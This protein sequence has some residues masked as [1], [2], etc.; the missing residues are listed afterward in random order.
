MSD[1]KVV[2]IIM[3]VYNGG[4]FLKDSVEDILAQTYRD[5]ELFCIYDDGTTDG[6]DKVLEELARKDSRLIVIH[7]EERGSNVCRN[8]GLREA[9]GKYV[10]FLDA[11]DRFEQDMLKLCVDKAEADN[12]DVVAFDGDLFDSKSGVHRGAP[13]LIRSSE[14]VST[15]DPFR[16][17][18]ATIW[19]KM[20]RRDL[21]IDNDIRFNK[22]LGGFPTYFVFMA[23][24]YASNIG[25]VR[26][27]L[28]HYR[29]NNENSLTASKENPTGGFEEF[30][31]VKKR[32]VRDGRFEEKK[33]IFER[34]AKE[35]MTDKLR[36]LRTKS[37]SETLYELL[38]TRGVD[39]LG[40]FTE[41]KDKDF[42][43]FLF[44]QKMSLI[45]SGVI[46]AS[47]F[48]LPKLHE[49]DASKIALY[50]G[51]EVGKDYA[52]QIMRSGNLKLVC[53]A[54]RNFERIGYPLQS[55]E[56]LKD[57]DYDILLIAVSDKKTADIITRDL[58]SMGI[59]E[60]KIFWKQ[61]EYI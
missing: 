20:I 41:Y 11:D 52:V 5:I 18:N 3:P 49:G 16:V 8:R 4:E 17:L 24:V 38:R 35:Y 12:C 36:V 46:G 9:K 6:S 58:I 32:L 42:A 19:N 56:I 29:V 47:C 53:W 51:G 61:P 25:L 54:D 31:D 43:T 23:L 39:E 22:P 50:G 7:N 21:L 45:R 55:P 60:E 28:I 37:G 14:E 44:E 57:K 2:S 33:E 10:I 27:V 1:N 13:F 26:K 40:L 30:V 34:Y 48:F 15:K 59:P